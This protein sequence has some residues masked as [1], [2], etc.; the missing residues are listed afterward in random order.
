MF[1][2]YFSGVYAAFLGTRFINGIV[3]EWQIYM[4]KEN[5]SQY[6]EKLIER[7]PLYVY[8]KDEQKRQMKQCLDAYIHGIKDMLTNEGRLLK[9]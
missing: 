2:D 3:S 1:E 6:Q 8:E 9:G 7:S 5:I 4:I